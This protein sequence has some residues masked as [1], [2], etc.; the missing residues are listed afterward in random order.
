MNVIHRIA[1][2]YSV[3]AR[4]RRARRFRQLFA[5]GPSTTLLDLGS[6]DGSHI[7]EVLSGTRIDPGNVYL[8]D[9]DENAVAAGARRFGFVP[10]VIGESGRL[11]FP[12]GFFD[13]VHCSSVLEHVTIPKSEVWQVRSGREFRS[14]SRQ[15]QAA[16]AGE[17]ARVGRQ[18]WV[19][20]PDRWFPVESHSWLPF[21]G[22]IPRRV[23]V[24]LLRVTNMFW[25]KQTAPDWNLLDAR[26]LSDLFPH[27]PILTER[28]LGMVKS[29]TAFK[30]LPDRGIG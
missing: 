7:A 6:G 24:P 10:V 20:T 2:N 11:P 1:R 30:R 13:I 28:S 9:L 15:A 19:Q 26:G 27:Q 29:V 25:V 17:I 3:R 22:W 23:L 16:F 5:I 12:D 21:A 14:R 4:R 8:A 18:F